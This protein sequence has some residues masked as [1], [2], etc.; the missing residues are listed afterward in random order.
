MRLP[1]VVDDFHSLHSRG[2][3]VWRREISPRLSGIPLIG[4]LIEAIWPTPVRVPYPSSQGPANLVEEAARSLSAGLL[5]PFAA[6]ITGKVLFSCVKSTPKQ[7]TLVRSFIIQFVVFLCS[8][9]L[10][11]SSILFRK[12]TLEDVLTTAGV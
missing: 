2:I 11:W 4:G 9:L 8:C 1:S 6:Y 12:N 7:V 10:G 3:A 5:L